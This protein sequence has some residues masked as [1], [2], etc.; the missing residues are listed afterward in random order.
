MVN[1]SLCNWFI[2]WCLFNGLTYL[3]M[4]KIKIGEILLDTG[5]LLLGDIKNLKKIDP[6]PYKKQARYKHVVLEQEYEYKIDFEKYTDILVDN[7]SVNELLE[8]ELL[9]EIYDTN[10]TELSIPNIVNGLANG[11]KQLKFDNGE[12][13]KAFAFLSDNGEGFCPIY[14]ETD[15][16]GNER[17]IIEL[18]KGE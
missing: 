10:D 14:L 15:E 3:A 17:L 6:K 2:Y 18:A 12:T 8:E 16:N 1:W 13:G 7:K 11:Y 4:E 5:V 9:E